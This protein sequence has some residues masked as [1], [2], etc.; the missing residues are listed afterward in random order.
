MLRNERVTLERGDAS[1]ELAGV[2]DTWTRKADVAKTMAGLDR[3][4]PT[5]VLAHDPQLFP[6]IAAAGGHVVLAGHTHWG[7]VAVPFLATRF[8]MSRLTY[9]YHAGLYREGAST[10]VIHPGLGTTGPPIRLGAAPEITIVRLRA[11]QGAALAA[12]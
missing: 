4:R 10:L 7:Q 5:L 3:A 6:A 11:G 2:D 9:R 12:A 8:N 1:L